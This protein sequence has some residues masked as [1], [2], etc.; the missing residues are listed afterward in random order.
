MVA[1]SDA[2]LFRKYFWLIRKESEP[3]KHLILSLALIMVLASGITTFAHGKHKTSTAAKTANGKV[4]FI[5]KGDGVTTC[6]VTGE[7]IHNKGVKTV[8]YRRTV[9]FC[10]AGCRA[11]A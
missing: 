11:D 1:E 7:A 4:V 9:Y 10:C 2:A 8:L 3:M 6:P 5:G